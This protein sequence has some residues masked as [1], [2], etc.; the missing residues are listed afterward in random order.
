MIDDKLISL[1]LAREIA[2]Y[3]LR[4]QKLLL[5][6]VVFPFLEK[7]LYRLLQELLIIFGCGFAACK[8]P[9]DFQER[10]LVDVSK[11]LLQLNPASDAAAPERR[12]RDGGSGGGRDKNT[13]SALA[14][15]LSRSCRLSGAAPHFIERQLFFHG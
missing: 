4:H 15:T 3:H 2:V 9:P 11:H 5:E 1:G 6:A 10:R 13:R 14:H 8:A 12:A 7:R